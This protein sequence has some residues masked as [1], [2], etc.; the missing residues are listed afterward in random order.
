MSVIQEELKQRPEELFS[1]LSPEPVAAAS[2]GQV[3]QILPL[4]SGACPAILPPNAG[5]LT[6]HPPCIACA[7]LR[8]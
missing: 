7:S 6:E 4:T 5:I 8:K 1:E 3:R 2:L